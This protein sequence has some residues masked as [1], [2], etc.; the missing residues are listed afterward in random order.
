MTYLHIS[1][2]ALEDCINNDSYGE[3]CVRCNACGRWDKSTQKESA[4]KM[5]KECLQKQY[6]FDN[7]IDGLEET[8]KKNIESNI[9]YFKEKIAELEQSQ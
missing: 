2:S 4:L 9:R 3:I 5:Y 8:Q 1:Y 6:D 7:W